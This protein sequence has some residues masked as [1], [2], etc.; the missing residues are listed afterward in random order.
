MTQMLA[1]PSQKR[2]DEQQEDC[3]CQY[4]LQLWVVG[5]NRHE[6]KER[7]GKGREVKNNNIQKAIKKR[8]HVQS[9]H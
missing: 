8:K 7:K 3:L 4:I 2:K 6:E 1:S 9:L 5:D